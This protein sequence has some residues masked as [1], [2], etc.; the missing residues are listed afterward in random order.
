MNRARRIASLQT[1]GRELQAPAEFIGFNGASRHGSSVLL[2]QGRHTSL[3]HGPF[4]L[5]RRVKLAF[6]GTPFSQDR[7]DRA[8]DHLD[9][10]CLPDNP[11]MN[12]NTGRKPS[13]LR[14]A[15]P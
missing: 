10:H 12:L 3:K 15:R 7:L 1:L 5:G 13:P 8:A 9:H 4:R 6:D 2:T 14:R 11:E